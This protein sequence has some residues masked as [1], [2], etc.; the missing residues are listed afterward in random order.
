MAWS[1]CISSKPARGD[2]EGQA[3]QVRVLADAY[4]L[5]GDQRGRLMNAVE[6][7]FV[8]NERFW[9]ERAM[10][11]P[12]VVSGPAIAEV[13]AWT[14]TEKAFVTRFRRVF[15]AALAGS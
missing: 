10:H 12:P 2:A 1:W 9:G 4:G 8:R 15:V 3:G 14:R 11:G 7:R 6:E 5:S 13:V